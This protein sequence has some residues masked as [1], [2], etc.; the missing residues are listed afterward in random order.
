MTVLISGI[1]KDGMGKPIPRCTIELTA[2]RTSSTVIAQTLASQTVGDDGRYSFTVEPGKYG[3]TLHVDTYMP[4]RVGE[5]VVRADAVPGTLNDFLGQVGEEDLTPAAILKFEAMVNLVAQQAA[6][7]ERSKAS[8]LQS[9]SD[10][11]ASQGAAHGSETASAGSAAEALV[12]KNA[13]KAS[14]LAAAGS[15]AEA[16]SSKNAAAGSATE[17]LASKNAGNASELAAATSARNAASSEATAVQKASQ[18]FLSAD[19][20][21]GSATE[22]LA[23][24]NAARISEQA[25]AGSAAEALASKNAAKASEL[26]V[27]GVVGNAAASERNAAT[28]ERNTATSERNAA[29]SESTATQKAAQAA[30]SANEAADSATLATTKANEIV[31]SAQS[32]SRSEGTVRGLIGTLGSLVHPGEAGTLPITPKLLPNNDFNKANVGWCKVAGRVVNGPA[33]S[34]IWN[35][36]SYGSVFSYNDAGQNSSETAEGSGYPGMWWH[37]RYFDTVGRTYFRHRIDRAAWSPWAL[38]WTGL[39]TTVDANGFI[40]RASPIV[41][42]SNDGACEC[43]EES[44]GV[45]A[46]RRS[47][48]VYV[49]SGTLGLNA[50]GGWFLGIPKDDNGQALIWVDYDVEANGDLIIR[51]FHRENITSPVFARNLIQGVAEGDP[52]DIPRGRVLDLRVHMPDSSVYNQRQSEIARNLPEPQETSLP[53]TDKT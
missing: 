28:S 49:V 14:E 6:Q 34:A 2:E 9:I 38:Y 25:A 8:V 44:E 5:I 29:A 22:A 3:V 42:L 12:S 33:D 43:N 11:Q 19:A 10:T 18:T 46:V 51:T 17:A 36:Q 39:N 24:K 1:L 15:A 21:S 53:Q 52:I 20:A 13:A 31:E 26:A 35:V 7:V 23:S 30:S 32:A 4:R 48:G 47:V 40:K 37:Q 45:T 16:L 41:K 50:D 27:A